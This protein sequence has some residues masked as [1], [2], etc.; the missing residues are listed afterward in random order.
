[1]IGASLDDRGS[2]YAL[3]LLHRLFAVAG[4][5]PTFLGSRARCAIG[6]SDAPLVRSVHRAD[7]DGAVLGADELPPLETIS[8]DLTLRS[9]CSLVAAG[10]G[11]L[12]LARG[13]Y[14]GRPLYYSVSHG[15]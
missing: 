8:D 14:G 13:P 2:T 5:A 9:A 12:L 3:S 11:A 10:D 4:V 7:L 6:C 15:G 1:M